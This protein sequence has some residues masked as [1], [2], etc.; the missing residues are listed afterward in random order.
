MECI[1]RKN[2]CLQRITV[3]QVL[4]ACEAVL[5]SHAIAADR[6]AALKSAIDKTDKSKPSKSAVDQLTALANQVDNDASAA[7]GVDADRMRSLASVIKARAAK[8][9]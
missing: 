9:R 6:A 3:S 1:E 5:R 7:S 8:L 2:E 4:Q